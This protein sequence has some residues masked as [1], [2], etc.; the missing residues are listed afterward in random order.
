MSDFDL[1]KYTVWSLSSLVKTSK[2]IPSNE[3][4][5]YL[6]IPF[7]KILLTQN[8]PEMLSNSLSAIASLMDERQTQNI[9]SSGILT[10]LQQIC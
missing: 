10:R 8:D 2:Q 1:L 6:M 5:D 7:I 3:F 4:N 9:V